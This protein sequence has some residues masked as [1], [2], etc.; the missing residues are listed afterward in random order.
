[1]TTAI[2]PII[3]P[4]VASSTHTWTAASRPEEPPRCVR[5]R[6]SAWNQLETEATCEENLAELEIELVLTHKRFEGFT[7]RDA[8]DAG[9]MLAS[10]LSH[11]LM[12]TPVGQDRLAEYFMQ[13]A[14]DL[15]HRA[16]KRDADAL[17][18]LTDEWRAAGR[19]GAAPP[20]PVKA[21]LRT[22]SGRSLMRSLREQLA[23][24]AGEADEG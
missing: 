17:R 7:R 13:A 9:L 24:A 10:F 3:E 19:P 18:E 20:S 6:A 22:E 2:T 1:M 12:L 5:C 23:P 21:D 8:A 15:R 14:L 4:T 11:N 16:L